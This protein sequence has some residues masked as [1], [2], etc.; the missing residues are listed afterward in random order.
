[1]SAAT[2]RYLRLGGFGCAL[3]A[4][5]GL[6]HPTKRLILN[7]T[8]SAPIGFY[9]LAGPRVV[10]GDL[11]LVR[12]P[13]ELARWMA[14]RRYLPLNVPLIKHVAA[15]D[16]RTV[17]GDHRRLLIDGRAVAEMRDRD[18]LGR[19]LTPFNGCRRLERGEVLLLNARAPDSFDGR[20]FGP[21]KRGTIVGRL[22]PLWT[23]HG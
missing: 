19:R 15:T 12:P 5:S 23:W 4:L 20:Y 17:C 14:R 13:T 3:L 9:W 1:M 2:R 16:G 7:T 21:L 22:V 11:A 10:D 18:R 6:C 8:A